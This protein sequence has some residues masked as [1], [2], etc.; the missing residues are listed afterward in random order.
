MAE[1][2]FSQYFEKL[3]SNSKKTQLKITGTYKKAFIEFVIK[4]KL[5]VE[6]FKG[7]NFRGYELSRFREFFWR[8]PTTVGR[9][10]G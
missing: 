2:N 9:S 7:I 5:E 6:Y 8:F 10:A 1:H 3:L 4:L